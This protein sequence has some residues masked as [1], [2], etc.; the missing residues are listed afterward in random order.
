MLQMCLRSGSCSSQLA[1]RSHVGLSPYCPQ[2]TLIMP[3]QGSSCGGVV[4]GFDGRETGF[5]KVKGRGAPN[6]QVWRCPQ[7]L[8]QFQLPELAQSPTLRPIGRPACPPKLTIL[9]ARGTI[10]CERS[11]CPDDMF[12]DIPCRAGHS[13]QDLPPPQAPPQPRL[14]EADEWMP[15]SWRTDREDE[16]SRSKPSRAFIDIEVSSK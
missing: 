8:Q 16:A 5:T 3:C 2:E 10:R 15:H 9:D 13:E 14:W 7:S 6:L 1:P 11:S 4:V 12:E